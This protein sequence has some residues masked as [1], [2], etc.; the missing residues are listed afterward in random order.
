MLSSSPE[1]L[2][3]SNE[4]FLTLNFL[5]FKSRLY[6]LWESIGEL[7]TIREACSLVSSKIF[8]SGPIQVSSDIADFSLSE[9]MGGFVTCANF[10][11]Q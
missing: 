1:F 11:R 6:F 3:Y 10:W 4:N 7:T 2:E 8:N 5:F 9:S